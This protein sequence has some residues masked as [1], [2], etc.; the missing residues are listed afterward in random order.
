MRRPAVRLGQE[1]PVCWP[2]SGCCEWD[3]HPEPHGA[4]P[5][6]RS[7]SASP[8][9][10]IRRQPDPLK[11]RQSSQTSA[12]E[13]GAPR[14][15]WRSRSMS[16]RCPWPAEKAREGRTSLDDFHARFPG[17]SNWLGL[18]EVERGRSPACWNE[19]ARDQALVPSMSAGSG[20]VARAP[21]RRLRNLDECIPSLQRRQL[22]SRNWRSS[23]PRI[24]CQ[25]VCRTGQPTLSSLAG[26]RR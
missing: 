11:E 6:R 21:R 17:E 10:T 25:S 24:S 1:L 12:R 8:Q 16:P 4:W 22:L 23:V 7:R 19:P 20:S 2:R 9:S 3:R 5:P 15:A 18:S 13:D 14:P 26:I